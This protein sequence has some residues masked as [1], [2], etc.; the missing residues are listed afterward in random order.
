[1]QEAV[2]GKIADLLME[3]YKALAAKGGF[4]VELR[5]A[6]LA[7]PEALYPACKALFWTQTTPAL[8][9]AIRAAARQAEQLHY[10]VFHAH[11]K[12]DPPALARAQALLE[13]A[14]ALCNLIP[15]QNRQT[16]EQADRICRCIAVYA[17]QIRDRPE[18]GA[19]GISPAQAEHSQ[20]RLRGEYIYN[21]RKHEGRTFAALSRELGLSDSRISQIY[22]REDWR[23]NAYA[24]DHYLNDGPALDGF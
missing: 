19:A 9:G 2:A 14:Q 3:Q 7:G 4:A 17:R 16:Q 6:A 5:A 13:A 1:M 8:Y 12:E 15:A 18:S 24:A 21:A 23:R 10:E 20:N 22:R 11:E